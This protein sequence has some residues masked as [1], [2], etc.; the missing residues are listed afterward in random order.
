M[1]I[2]RHS[3]YN[4]AG[5]LAP[6][7]VTLVT[8][9]TYLRLIGTERYGVLVIVWIFLGY[10]GV[11][12]L[13]LGRATA[14][15]IANLHQADPG[16]RAD[17][18]WTALM[19]NTSFGVVGGLL[20]WPVAR[21]FFANHF[22]VAEVLRLEVLATVPWMAA[23]VPI[24]TVSGVLGGALQGR[25]RFLA[26][27]AASVLGSALYQILPLTVAWMYGPD[28]VWLVPAALLGRVVTF[29]VLFAQCYRHVPLN[30]ASSVRRDLVVPLFRF[31]GWVT[32]SGFINPL[33]TT[34]DRFLIG[35]IAG[36]KALTYYTVP[37]NLAS[38]VIVLP[39]SLSDT[40]FPRFS[41]TS[42]E[43]RHR[44]M[45]EAVRA[46]SVILTP[47]IIAG[48]LIM[49]PFLT[50]WVGSEV[51]GNSAHVGEIIALGLWFNGLAYIPYARLQAQG[52]PDLV[53]K[54]HIAEL[55]PYLVILALALH[56]WGVVGAALAWSLRVTVDA[57][58]LFW[59]AGDAIRGFMAHLPPLLLL[60]IAA[61]AVFAFPFGSVSRWA[62]GASTLLGS[63]AWA[64]L[65]APESVKRLVREGYQLRPR[66]DKA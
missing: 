51:A 13:G 65:A 24:A 31:G 11:F 4:L 2:R 6:I 32:V 54:C 12:D 8:V 45:D 21:Y 46:L 7:V 40:L 53:A 29:V 43:E 48:I 61:A 37:F 36:A 58:L 25:E 64:W 38:R 55:F 27:N 39:G 26:L 5:S 19:L 42:K 9:P 14:Q 22:Q 1:S 30:I 17:T 20:L 57:M 35:S 23:A 10:F 16:E 34:L 63:L 18:F 62:V 66:T 47:L 33:L 59:M 44:L 50:W 41:A 15:R 3:I 56:A 52:R 28:L 49:E 60:G